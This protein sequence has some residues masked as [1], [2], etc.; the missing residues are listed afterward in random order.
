[1]ATENFL[2]RASL[3]CQIEKTN[4]AHVEQVKSKTGKFVVLSLVVGP[5]YRP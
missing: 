5:K 3:I 4:E 1:M 2:G